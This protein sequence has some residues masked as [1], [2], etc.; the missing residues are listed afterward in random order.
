MARHFGALSKPQ[1]QMF[2]IQRATI[3]WVEY[4]GIL[5]VGVAPGGLY[6]AVFAGFNIGHAPLLVPWSA[7]GEFKSTRKF[8][9]TQYETTVSLPQKGNVSLCFFNPQIVAEIEEQRARAAQPQA[10]SSI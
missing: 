7:L 5:T 1:A 6:L 4:K 3:G 10:F 8:W 9:M 2:W